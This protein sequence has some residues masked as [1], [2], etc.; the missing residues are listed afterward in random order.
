[1]SD[2]P[3]KV[4][5][6]HVAEFLRREHGFGVLTMEEI[7]DRDFYF[8]ED[9]LWEFLKKTQNETI[10]RLEEDYGSDARDEVFKALRDELERRPLWSIIRTGLTVRGHDI[11]LY[12]PKPRSSG[13]VVNELYA[14][15]R[16]TFI[17]EIVI[18]GD[19]RPEFAIFLNG[20]PI[21]TVDLKHEGAGQNVH[22][23]VAQYVISAATFSTQ[24][25]WW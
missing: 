1:M 22:D 21:V 14:E 16:V 11:K 12:F 4:F 6:N 9:H 25:R 8:A 17:P 23:A 24:R 5:Q 7:T 15:N 20:L 19:K 13:S 10:E 2:K 18:R 3:E